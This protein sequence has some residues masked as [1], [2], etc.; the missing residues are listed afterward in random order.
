MNDEYRMMNG[1]NTTN[2]PNDAPVGDMM[3]RSVS[4]CLGRFIIRHSSFVIPHFLFL[5]LAIAAS[6]TPSNKAEISFH[7]ESV[8]E[9]QQYTLG[10]IADIKGA[11]KEERSRW[12]SI[13]LGQS[14]GLGIRLP[15]S[16]RPLAALL[17]R[18]G[19]D[20][21]EEVTAS[22]P[23]RM[24]VERA[25][26]DLNVK[27]LRE[28]IEK[29]I[30]ARMPFAEGDLV[31]ES[32]QMPQSVRVP[33]GKVSFNIDLHLPTRPS[34]Y[35]AY[36]ADILVDDVSQRKVSGTVKMDASVSV[37]Q[38]GTS[39]ISRGAAVRPDSCR[40]VHVRLSQLR[41]RP[42]T[43][44][45]LKGVITAKRDLKPGDP[46]LWSNVEKQ[47]LVRN[48][49]TVRMILENPAG[50]QIATQGMARSNGALGDTVDVVNVTSGKR[51]Q[52]VVIA[53]KTVSVDW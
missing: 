44:D 47:V 51:I 29:E 24:T 33:A 31:I 16:P 39:G 38:V 11:T 30:R 37:L 49:Q 53:E 2:F 7:A 35:A 20:M 3:G 10:D 6:A 4:R 13:V 12:E 15:L 26:Q 8:V 18:R 14:P 50:L 45:D 32:V 27:A 25:S 23:K 34:G 1:N 48:G 28:A 52:G 21:D 22:F 41:D 40:R 43:E 17:Q 42:V 5:F 19:L 9:G 46:L 36:V